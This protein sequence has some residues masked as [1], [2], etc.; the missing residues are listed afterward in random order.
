MKNR[1][2][3]YEPEWFK[4]I[5]SIQN[6]EEPNEEGVPMS[7]LWFISKSGNLEVGRVT[8]ETCVITES[9]KVNIIYLVDVAGREAIVRRPPFE[10]NPF[11]ENS[12][13]GKFSGDQFAYEKYVSELTAEEFFD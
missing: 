6:G 4:A 13:V 8:D 7:C 5:L 9:G 11:W 1:I 3:D 12:P 10:A 2:T